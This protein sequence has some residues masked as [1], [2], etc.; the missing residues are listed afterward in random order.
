MYHTPAWKQPGK[1]IR[2]IQMMAESKRE[3]STHESRKWFHTNA[4][5]KEKKK[6]RA[7]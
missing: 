5:G 2:I 6:K 4:W 3:I 1:D 7:V